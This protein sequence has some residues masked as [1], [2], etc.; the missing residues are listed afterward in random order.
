MT[1]QECY[2]NLGGDYR[3]VENRLMR[4]SLVKKFIAMFP[5]DGSFDQLCRAMEEGNR[6]DA[7]RA[8][9]TLKGICGNLSLTKL[10]ASSSRLTELL[11]PEADT[12]PQEAN[13]LLETVRKD[14]ELAVGIIRAFLNQDS[15][16]A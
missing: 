13:A 15:H 5:E 2:Q 8:A 12:I 1:I 9:H 10:Y 7:F 3:D 11:R 4:E 14:Y 16:G 6:Q